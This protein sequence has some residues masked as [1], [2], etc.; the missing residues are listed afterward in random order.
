MIRLVEKKKP[1]IYKTQFHKSTGA[2]ISITKAH[3]PPAHIRSYIHILYTEV[4]LLTLWMPNTLPFPCRH[5]FYKLGKKLNH[6][7][8]LGLSSEG[9]YVW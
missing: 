5:P 7:F 3:H 4:A 8:I 1:C 2:E 6:A 9:W